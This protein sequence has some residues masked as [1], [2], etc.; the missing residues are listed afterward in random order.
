MK[1]GSKA[2]DSRVFFRDQV[3][4]LC[5]ASGSTRLQQSKFEGFGK[6]LGNLVSFPCAHDGSTLQQ[7]PS[8]DVSPEC[9]RNPVSIC[10]ST[11]HSSSRR[12]KAS[13][14]LRSETSLITSTAAEYKC[15]TGGQCLS[16]GS[17]G[18][19]AS[20]LDIPSCFESAESVHSRVSRVSAML[21]PARHHTS[22]EHS[23]AARGEGMWG[24]IVLFMLWSGPCGWRG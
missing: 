22:V 17:G 20:E 5:S 8:F 16:T 19:S 23:S 24:C 9:L 15:V 12:F 18:Q 6:R 10:G 13:A 2:K 1:A 14:R 4:K 3:L 21:S 11:P 7:A